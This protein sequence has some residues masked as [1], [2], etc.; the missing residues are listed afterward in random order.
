MV[1]PIPSLPFSTWAAAMTAAWLEPRYFPQGVLPLDWGKP[2]PA[3]PTEWMQNVTSHLPLYWVIRIKRMGNCNWFRGYCLGTGPRI[4]NLKTWTW[5]I[6]RK[7]S[8][9][10]HVQLPVLWPILHKNKGACRERGLVWRAQ[11]LVFWLSVQAF[12]SKT[13]ARRETKTLVGFHCLWSASCNED[14]WAIPNISQRLEY[15]DFLSL[16]ETLNNN[17]SRYF[18]F[19]KQHIRRLHWWR[20]GRKATPLFAKLLRL[21]LALFFQTCQ[22]NSIVWHVLCAWF[23][24]NQLQL[25]AFDL[26]RFILPCGARCIFQPFQ[27]AVHKRSPCDCISSGSTWIQWQFGSIFYIVM[28]RMHAGETSKSFSSRDPSS[29]SCTVAL[30][31]NPEYMYIYT[32]AIIGVYDVY[33]YKIYSAL[34]YIIAVVYTCIFNCVYTYYI[35][36]SNTWNAQFLCILYRVL[37]V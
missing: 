21:V 31:I 7:S 8:S 22:E 24:S 2:R 35:V 32:L 26:C 11:G 10:P 17:I 12:R 30:E 34:N 15:L 18:K 19:L 3:N 13:C 25:L 4:E 29:V 20:G 5:T 1:L 6:E 28:Q 37:E 9:Y 16:C 36:D 23:Q 33:I 14:N 27:G